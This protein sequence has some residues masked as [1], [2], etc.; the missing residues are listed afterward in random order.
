M[1]A[2]IERRSIANSYQKLLVLTISCRIYQGGPVEHHSKTSSASTE[3]DYGS[4]YGE[5][6]SGRELLS[7][8]TQVPLAAAALQA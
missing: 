2:L 5:E 7:E 8:D 1:A 6:P 4:R 3:L